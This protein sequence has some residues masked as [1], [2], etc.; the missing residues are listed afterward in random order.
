MPNNNNNNNIN[1]I[2]VKN[3]L[4]TVKLWRSFFI[5]M[6]NEREFSIFFRTDSE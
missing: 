1:T 5:L 2:A 4:L 6:L 3:I